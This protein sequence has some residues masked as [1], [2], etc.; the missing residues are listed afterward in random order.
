[1]SDFKEQSSKCQ[2]KLLASGKEVQSHL[3]Y[4]LA[5]SSKI[6][7]STQH[8]VFPV[9]FITVGALF[10]VHSGWHWHHEWQMNKA[11]KL[12]PTSFHPP[13][14]PAYV[15]LGVA[16]NFSIITHTIY[17]TFQNTPLFP[18]IW[19]CPYIP[20]YIWTGFT[21]IGLSS[22]INQDTICYITA[23]SL[24]PFIF[25]PFGHKYFLLLN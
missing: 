18:F 7:E 14:S 13:Y 12:S 15:C 10:A 2:S 21:F 5:M 23:T 11:T 20:K 9:C 6:Q 1:M 19:V 25:I 8:K 22:T 16:M 4:K 3:Q 24:I 17:S